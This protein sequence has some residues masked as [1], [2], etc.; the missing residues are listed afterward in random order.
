VFA[1]SYFF[2][3][4]FGPDHE[5][6]KHPSAE[7][8]SLADELAQATADGDRDR[9][10]QLA[11]QLQAERE[12]QLG[13][14][15]QWTAMRQHF[16]EVLQTAIAEGVVGNRR[17]LRELFRELQGRSRTY[18]DD[19]QQAWMD[20]EDGGR[21]RRVGLSED[22]VVGPE[23]DPRLGL[24]LLLARMEYL[25]NAKPKHRELY[26]QMERDWQLLQRA[27]QVATAR[28]TRV[29]ASNQ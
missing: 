20:V 15:R 5:L 26:P 9:R 2:T 17:E 16:D 19:N 6:R 3:G 8:A 13:D 24:Q 4:R 27:E 11:L 12:R 29:I 28:D 1:A 22:N 23:S 10:K 21:L 14:V 7:A 18:V 25:L